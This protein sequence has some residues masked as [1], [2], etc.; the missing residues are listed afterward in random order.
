MDQALIG[1]DECRLVFIRARRQLGIAERVA[2]VG[3]EPWDRVQRV[4]DPISGG[5]IGIGTPDPVDELAALGGIRR[6]QQGFCQV[7]IGRIESM[8]ISVQRYGTAGG[9]CTY[10]GEELAAG[11]GWQ[12]VCDAA[13]GRVGTVR[14][15]GPETARGAFEKAG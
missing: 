9:A 12:V 2:L 5:V 4:A 15:G 13:Q 6:A 8:G 14:A 7:V 1:S 3:Q 10:I 11:V